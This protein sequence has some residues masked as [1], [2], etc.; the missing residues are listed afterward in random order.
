MSF[1]ALVLDDRRGQL[2]PLTDLRPAFD[3]RTGACTTL[4]RFSTVFEIAGL[5]VSRDIAELVRQSHPDSDIN[6]C[7]L[8]AIESPAVFVLNGRAP[9][10]AEVASNLKP[11][12]LWCDDRTGDL[13]AAC[14]PIG[15]LEALLAGTP[16]GFSRMQVTLASESRAAG[17]LSRPWHIR[18]LRDACIREDL[19]FHVP[20]RAKQWGWPELAPG[21]LRWGT[22]DLVVAP[23]ATVWPGVFLDNTTGPIWID[24]HATVRPGSII[25]GPAYIG[26]HS[27]VLDRCQIKPNTVIGPHC[28]VAGEIGGTIFQGFANK[29]HDGHLGDS[30]VGEWVNLGAGTTNSNLLNT[31]GEVITRPIRTD[32]SIGGNERTGEQFLGAIIGDHAKFAIC[33]RIMTGAIVGTGTMW[34]ATSPVAGTIAPFSWVTDAGTRKYAISKFADVMRTVMAR[35]QLSPSEAY[36]ER[37]SAL[38]EGDSGAR[39]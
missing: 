35:R 2:S 10:A 3:L 21:T 22:E 17:M 25:C 29:A 28:K 33:S 26:P 31:Y 1:P 34:A 15:S 5:L 16:D 13:I 7:A 27:A 20:R 23:T 30:F 36:L 6:E 37:L 19:G 38:Y 24:E 8:G 11:G 14:S 12:Q 9:L 18:S 39:S 4:E 32:G